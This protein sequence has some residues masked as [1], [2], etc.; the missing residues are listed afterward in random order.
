MGKYGTGH[1]YEIIKKKILKNGGKVF[2]NHKVEKFKY[3]EIFY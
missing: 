2:L 3:S 1:L